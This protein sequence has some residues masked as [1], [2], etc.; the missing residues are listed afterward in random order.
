M[1]MDDAMETED[2]GTV[3]I[4]WAET[5]HQHYKSLNSNNDGKRW[6]AALIV[7]WWQVS[8]DMWEHRNGSH[9]R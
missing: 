8:W 6:L 2:L 5:Q 1:T 3:V 9:R 7:K 4:G